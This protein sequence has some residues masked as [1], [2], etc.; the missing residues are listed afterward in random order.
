M[1]AAVPLRLRPVTVTV[2]LLPAFLSANVALPP[3][4][5][6]LSVPITP[7]RLRVVMV[8]AVVAS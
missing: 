4:K 3:V 1:P 7:V 6:T 8:A 5:L 2:L